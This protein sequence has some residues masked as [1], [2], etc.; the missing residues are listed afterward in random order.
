MLALC[1]GFAA[2]RAATAATSRGHDP[3]MRGERCALQ[4][5]RQPLQLMRKR[6]S[7]Q[8]RFLRQLV[9]PMHLDADACATPM[10][11]R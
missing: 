3:A 4:P 8:L 6:Q 10:P 1:L 5:L 11:G 7:V 9:R 2:N